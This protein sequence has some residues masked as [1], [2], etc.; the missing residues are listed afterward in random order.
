[1]TF[2]Y[3]EQQQFAV[4]PLWIKYLLQVAVLL[5]GFNC[6]VLATDYRPV[7]WNGSQPNLPVKQCDLISQ[8]ILQNLPWKRIL[9]SDFA[10]MAANIAKYWMWQGRE[11]ARSVIRSFIILASCPRVGHV[12][13][14][15]EMKSV[16]IQSYQGSFL[17]KIPI[18]PYPY[19]P[20]LLLL[21][22][23]THAGY[24]AKCFSKNVYKKANKQNQKGINNNFIDLAKPL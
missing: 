17:K 16:Y 12:M 20:Y 14:L 7:P 1:M 15:F 24:T 19:Y 9:G 3:F 18:Y 5:T 4:C 10:G 6:E 8:F 22:T 2:R 13:P 23:S 11:N 21:L